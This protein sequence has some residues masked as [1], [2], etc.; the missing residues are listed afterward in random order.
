M[1]GRPQIMSNA[2]VLM[3]AILE[4]GLT[5]GEAAKLSSVSPDLLGACMH[6]DRYISPKTAGRLLAAFGAEAIQCGNGVEIR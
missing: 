6:S 4:R 2:Q 3:K 5:I 1:K